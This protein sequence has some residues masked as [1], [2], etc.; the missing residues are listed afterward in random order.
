MSELTAGLKTKAHDL[1]F[2]LAGVTSPDPPPHIEAFERWIRSGRHGEM[3]YLAAD[4]SRV[5]RGDPRLILP[6]CQSILVLATNYAQ[7]GLGSSPGIAA[8]AQGMDYHE[9]L[10]DRARELVLWAQELTGREFPNRIYSDTGPVLERELAQRA[11]LGWIGKNT[12]LIH[13]R[14]GSY[15][16]LT[17]ILLG[18]ALDLDEPVL[19]DYCG[20]CSR[21]IEA[22]PTRCIL[23]DRT[24]D[25]RRCISYLT[26]ELRESIPRE[27]RGQVGEWIFGCDICQ[28]VC[29]WNRTFAWPT[30]DAQLLPRPLLANARPHFF[31]EAS[32]EGILEAIRGTTL[33]RAKLRGVRRNACVVAGNRPDP[34]AVPALAGLLLEDRHPTVRAHAAWA[35]G[36][37]GSDQAMELLLTASHGE[38]DPRVQEEI[39]WALGE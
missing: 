7:P 34:T 26:I 22:C 29:P 20:T 4:R 31:L 27:L 18:I 32:D 15:V 39:H 38:A 13:P 19:R 23:P 3:T 8:Y 28:Q 14:I 25:A 5:R 16:L 10:V 33:K 6:E 1:G 12:C 11:G 37:I 36:R 21:C 9:V 17:E 24:L 2:T 35:L 30:T